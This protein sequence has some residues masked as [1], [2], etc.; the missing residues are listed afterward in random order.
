[1][2]G[3]LFDFDGTLVDTFDGIVTGIQRMRLQLGAA[4]LADEEIRRHIGWGIE[5]L[6]GQ[7]HPDMDAARPERLPPDGTPLPLAAERITAAIEIFRAEYAEIIMPMSRFYPGI[8]ALTVDLWRAGYRLAIV[9][10]KPVR[11]IHQF[12]AGA[13]LEAP[14]AVVLGADSTAEKKPAATPLLHAARELDVPLETCVMVGDSQLD[15]AAAQAAGIPS[16]AVTWGLLGRAAL[17]A[18][19]PTRLAETAAELGDA[20]H[21]LQ[22]LG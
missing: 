2:P 22:P 5:N 20:I 19:A 13:A 6:I 17:V 15:I 18:C 3:V 12:L 14:F 7:S 1:M 8:E 9:S 16:I 21:A 11:F 10:N 4:R